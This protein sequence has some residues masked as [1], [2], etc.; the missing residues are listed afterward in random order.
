VEED[1]IE[2]MLGVLWMNYKPEYYF[3]DM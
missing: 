3:F 2:R 1:G